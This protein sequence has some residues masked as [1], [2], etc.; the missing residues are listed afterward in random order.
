[1]PIGSSLIFPEGV[2]EDGLI[3]PHCRAQRGSSK[4]LRN[5]LMFLSVTSPALLWR[6]FFLRQLGKITCYPLG[7]NVSPKPPLLGLRICALAS[8][9]YHI[10]SR[11][12]GGRPNE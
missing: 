4:G 6:L 1:M 9:L 3:D 5:H 7:E 11:A 10:N 2:A 12:A 8:R